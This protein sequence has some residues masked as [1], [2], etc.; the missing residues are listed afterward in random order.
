M[1]TRVTITLDPD[2]HRLAKQVA[3]KKHTTV[4]G[5]IGS[6]LQAEGAVGKMDLVASMTGIDSLRDP[7]IGSDPLFDAL[8]DKY[9]R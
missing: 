2:V 6:L 5:L 3:R 9:I 7:A 8:R 1:K 4:S